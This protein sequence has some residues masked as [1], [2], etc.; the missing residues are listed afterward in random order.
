MSQFPK[1]NDKFYSAGFDFGQKGGTLR[2]TIESMAKLEEGIE[3][4]IPAPDYREI[5]SKAFS[6]LI[7][8]L[9]GTLSRLR[10]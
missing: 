9:D 5:E 6:R 4:A 3:T 7:G 10:R 2:K 8:F 1:I